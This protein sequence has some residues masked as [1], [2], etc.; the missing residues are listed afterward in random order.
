MSKRIVELD[1]E[2]FKKLYHEV[3]TEGVT[4]ALAVEVD[5]IEYYG[6]FNYDVYVKKG[7]EDYYLFTDYDLTDNGVNNIRQKK[8]V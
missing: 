6:H 4:K 2:E 3:N 7:D 8:G 1:L 5:P